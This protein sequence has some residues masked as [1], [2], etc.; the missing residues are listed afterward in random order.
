MMNRSNKFRELSIKY[1]VL[2][3][4]YK[5]LTTLCFL[6][7]LLVSCT[8]ENR[9]AR[10]FIKEQKTFP[11]IVLKPNYL[12]KTNLKDDSLKN[13]KFL[14]ETIKDSILLAESTFLKDVKDTVFL[15]F[16]FNNLT[17]ELKAFGLKVYIDSSSIDLN[18]YDTLSYVFNI[19]QLELEENYIPFAD[20]EYIDTS[21]YVET[22]ILNSVSLNSWFERTLIIKGQKK[23]KVLF[24]EHSANDEINGGFKLD[25]FSGRISYKYKR[26]DIKLEDVYNLAVYS[27]KKNASY[28]Y[29]YILNQQIYRRLKL[30][31]KSKEIYYHYNRF[32]NYLIPANEDRFKV[33]K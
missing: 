12:F 29:D 23:N 18:N 6:L 30:L 22:F 5:I 27:G 1:Q 7:L 8:L 2:K 17:E 13:S 14:P 25:Y 3:N 26:D 21:R 19:S 20:E 33:V 16:Y 15:F 28:I 31:N 32:N 24:A 11:I 9:M 4:T 10:D